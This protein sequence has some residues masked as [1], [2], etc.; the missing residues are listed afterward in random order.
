VTTAT[1]PPPAY[2]YDPLFA[3][4]V[5]RLHIPDAFLERYSNAVRA[6]FRE[7]ARLLASEATRDDGINHCLH[8]A[9]SIVLRNPE[10]LDEALRVIRG[11]LG[12]APDPPTVLTVATVYYLLNRELA[13]LGLEDA[14]FRES[15]ELVRQG[16][17]QKAWLIGSGAMKVLDMQR[18]LK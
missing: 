6:K 2:T 7:A 13:R 11:A 15:I 16:F 1:L 3:R 14:E 17:D 12:E 4:I 18:S 9:S 5:G 8:M 10:H